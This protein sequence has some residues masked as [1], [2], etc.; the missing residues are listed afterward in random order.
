MSTLMLLVK[1]EDDM[2]KQTNRIVVV[3]KIKKR[4]TVAKVN[5]IL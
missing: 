4:N 2:W 1:F 3:I 5:L